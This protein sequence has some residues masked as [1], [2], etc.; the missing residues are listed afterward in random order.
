[1]QVTETLSEGLK[2]GFTV[3]VPGPDIEGKRTAR[4]SEISRTL[5]L[6]GFRPGKVPLPIVRQRYGTAVMA[7]VLE[8]SVNDATRQMLADRGLRSAVQ[9]KVELVS[10]ADPAAGKEAADL[11]F[12][13]EV[14]L[15]PEITLP[16]L[17]D[18]ALVRLKSE[19]TAEVIDAALAEVA[20]RQSVLTDVTDDRGAEPGETLTVDYLGKIDGV[21]FPGGTGTDMSVEV[22]G[23][24]FIPG[25]SE[26]MAGMKVGESR[27]IDV[28]F[29]E[30]Y[31]AKEL[32]G[33]AA[34]FELTA[35]ALRRSEV[36]AIDDAMA[37]KMGF[38]D[39]LEKMREA[40]AATIQRE[41]DQVS[42]LRL[43]RDLLDQL[44]GKA[45]FA[46]PESLVE[47]EFKQI[48]DRIEADRAAGKTDEDDAGK[49]DDTLRA[50][51]RAIAERRVRLGLLLAEIGRANG[52]QVGQDELMRAMRAE[53]SRYQGQE[54]QVME[55]FQKN[56]QAVE[57][58][59]GP[60][61]E[62]KVVDYIVELAKVE[63]KAVTVEELNAEPAPSAAPG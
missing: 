31:G 29:P 61:F 21:A 25:F 40:I 37:T 62:E 39:G 16:D 14:E 50:D 2:R 45:D 63:D 38:E 23:T 28:T 19:P 41:Y 24:G 20:K 34:T 51:Y 27:T 6:P 3:V 49:D 4:L 7:E 15:L 54:R 33:K 47:P 59:R 30:E 46:V 53:A 60:I 10:G 58:L 35:K 1:M 52:I 13:V 18:L 5:R 22:G 55:F 32:A 57:S 12:K 9:P 44:A 26:Q 11:E 43:K 8:E 56:P 42:R 36:P 48:W 17:S